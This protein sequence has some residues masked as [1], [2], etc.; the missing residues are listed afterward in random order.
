[1]SEPAP[2][3]RCPHCGACL[4]RI[5]LPDGSGWEGQFH[6]VCFNDDCPYFKE[7]WSWMWEQY[8]IHASYRYR[9]LN[10]RTGYASPLP[11]W[12]ETAIRDRIVKDE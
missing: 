2:M 1:M 5:T 9:I 7:G 4:D 11:V 10:P 3:L 8:K 6:L 12:S